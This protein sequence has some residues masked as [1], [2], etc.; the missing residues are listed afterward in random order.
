MARRQH[1]AV[2][3]ELRLQRQTQ[4][5]MKLEI[6]LTDERY[7]QESIDE[8]GEMT[9]TWEADMEDCSIHAWFRVFESVLGAAGMSEKLIMR[10]ACQLAFNECRDMKEMMALSNEYDLDFAAEQARLAADKDE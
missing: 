2:Y 6:K 9:T 3:D 4:S 1:N 5:A 8:P 10:G 7:R